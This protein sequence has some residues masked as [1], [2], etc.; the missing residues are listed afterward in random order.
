MRR[1]EKKKN[2][3]KKICFKEWHHHATIQSELRSKTQFCFK[4]YPKQ[5]VAVSNDFKL[6]GK[7]LN[8]ITDDK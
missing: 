8:H 7:F 6:Y 5:D 3:E 4:K 1:R 2:Q